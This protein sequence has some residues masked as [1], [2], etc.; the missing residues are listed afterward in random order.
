M[1][2]APPHPVREGL[3]LPARKQLFL[4]TVAALLV[5]LLLLVPELL[6]RLHRPP[7][8]P[9]ERL[10]PGTFRATPQQIAGL[11]IAPV[12]TMEFRG[13]VVTDG[14]IAYNDDTTTPVFSPYSGRVTR[15]IARQGDVVKRNA[16]L[17]AVE[18][19]EFV[20]GENDLLA[21]AAAVR[22]ARAQLELAQKTEQ[23]QHDLYGAQAGA[24]KDWLQAQSDLTAAQG[25]LH[26]A[27]VAL[28]SARNRLRI[29]GRSDEEIAAVEQ[30][31]AARA[32]SPEALVRAPISGSVTQRQVGLGQYITSASAGAST[33]VYTISD[34]RT[35]WLVA[36]VRETDAP[37]LH[38]GQPVEVRALA[39]PDRAFK[40]KVSWIA[41]GVDPNTHRIALRAEV[42]N[43]DGALRP[44]MFASF[45][46]TTGEP[47]T[48]PGVPEAAVV[49][50]G[51]EAHVF[52][53]DGDLL[54]IRF[55]K[56]GRTRDHWV[57]VTSG[58]RPGE[59]IVTAGTLFIDRAAQAQ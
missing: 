47:S 18:A 3:R 58:L 31:G 33:P 8:Q 59:K 28:Y 50:E 17:M 11:R 22:T 54:A 25:A 9:A 29:L 26:S 2:D 14:S 37:F 46:I 38:R 43:P 55:I 27:E 45:A 10:P 48:S 13:E 42:E 39:F 6:S 1:P 49:Y 23:R 24:L 36:N 5:L 35:V 51:N 15:L 7:P 40:A 56:T 19:S 20:Q 32:A 4:V 57:E 16:P 41:P 12:T 53:A 30:G 44:M 52:V 34:L 21:A